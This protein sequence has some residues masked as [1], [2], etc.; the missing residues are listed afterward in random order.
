MNRRMFIG[1]GLGLCT[2]AIIIPP[3]FKGVISKNDLLKMELECGTVT[4]R[5]FSDIAPGHV[6][7][8]KTLVQAG[9]YDGMPFTRVIEGF[10]AQTGEPSKEMRLNHRKLPALAAEFSHL[11]FE[12]GTLGM[13]RSR[14]P[15]SATHQ[16]FITTAR[17]RYLEQ[18]YTVFGKVTDGMELIDQLQYGHSDTGSVVNPELIKSISFATAE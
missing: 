1:G 4:M 18:N 14:H 8:I 2:G 7:R 11:P 13:A 15:H 3:L 16:F 9:F 5:L 10:M 6:E 17:A 12:R